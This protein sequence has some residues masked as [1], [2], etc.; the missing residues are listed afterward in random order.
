MNQW[1]MQNVKRII[2]LERAW[3]CL[4]GEEKE[5]LSAVSEYLEDEWVWVLKVTQFVKE[6]LSMKINTKLQNAK[7]VIQV[8]I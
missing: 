5:D 2:I 6:G 4:T 1:L 7:V 8:N 3:G